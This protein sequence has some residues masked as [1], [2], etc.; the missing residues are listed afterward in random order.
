MSKNRHIARHRAESP[1]TMQVVSK[2]VSSHA[3]T[4]GRPAAVLVAASGIMFGAALPASAGTTTT[5]ATVP[6]VE[7]GVQAAPLAAPAAPAPVVNAPTHTVQAGD[8]LGSIA[9]SYGVSLE[10]VFAANGLGWDSI[11]YPGQVISLSGSAAAAPAPA[12]PA[13]VAPAPVAPA[14]QVAPAPVETS[15]MGVTTASSSITVADGASSGVGAA[16]LASA[17][18][19]LAAGS[20]QDCTRLIEIAMAAAGQPVGDL[21]PLQFADYG[22]RVSS[23][24]PGDL[25]IR[26][27]HVGIYAGGGQVISSGMNG[28]NLT[29]QHPLTDLP[30]SFFVRL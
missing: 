17:R 16:I 20:I 2:A 30:G 6:A 4:V 8:T 25:V 26:P 11:I 19:Q 10:A 1:S 13:P 22:T 15:T 23:P 29:M 21:G 14:P 5:S 27:G 3:G 28:A 24:A 18:A 7:A 9:A 12:A